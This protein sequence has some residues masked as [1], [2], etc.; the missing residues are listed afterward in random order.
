MRSRWYH[1][2]ILHTAHHEERKVSWLELFYDLIF[3]AGIIQLGDAL[4]T[5]VT[6]Q[7]AV[8]G[9][10]AQF[11]G[12]FSALW[13][14]WTGFTFFANRFDV[15]D[16][17]QRFLVFLQMFSLGAMAISAPRVLI[18]DHVPFALANVFALGLVALM[19][20]RAHKQ[21]PE[22][23]NY[24]RYWGLVFGFGSLVFAISMFLKGPAIWITWAVA[25]F[26]ILVTPFSKT[27]RALAEEFPIDMEHLSERYGLL[28]IIVLGESFVKVLTYLAGSESA[29]ESSYLIK[30][31]LALLV[32]CCIWWIYFDDVA[33]AELKEKRGSWIIWFLGHLPL[34]ISITAV[35][36]AVKKTLTFDLSTTPDVVYV[37]FLVG[38]LTL[39]FFSVGLL[40]SVTERG[41]QE[42]NDKYR[43]MLRFGFGFVFLISGQVASGSDFSAGMFLGLLIIACVSQVIL[44]MFMAPLGE[45][46]V[47]E[48]V[49]M[50]S[51]VY[52]ASLRGE[53]ERPKVRAD[54][55]TAVRRGTP[56]ELRRD[57]YFFFIE[58]SWTRLLFTLIF[59]FGM[60]N[61]GF[62]AL[63]MLDPGAIDGGRIMHFGDAFNFSVQTMS[64]IGYGSMSP[65]SE[66]ANL[67]VTIEAAFGILGAALA[68][69]IMLAKASRPSASVLFS[70]VLVVNQYGG[71]PTLMFRAANAR[72]NDVVEA[73][74]S[75]SVLI[76]ELTPEGQHLRRV[77]DLKL[78]RDRSP[79]FTLTWQ[80]MHVIDED[81]PLAGVDW[82]DPEGAVLGFIVTLLGFD[83]TLGQQVHAR[84]IYRP[85]SLRFNHRYED[86]LS[87]LPDG[88]LMLDFERFHHT[89]PSDSL[90]ELDDQGRITGATDGTLR[91]SP[92]DLDDE[93]AEEEE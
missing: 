91:S 73:T 19:Y 62:A 9:P 78:V 47:H 10:L 6:E 33:G 5:Q 14:A 17:L 75:F 56:S 50:T 27:S 88:R 39:V 24:S 69:G 85:T 31:A 51:D 48:E 60:A 86:V 28:T 58:G 83:G 66:W 63:Y 76:D 64:T 49:H 41:N 59:I 20:F 84:H 11:A 67:V 93:I 55:S 15:D 38:A 80:V 74:V 57:L 36:V 61:V 2:P 32:T 45:S 44:D 34:T 12:L 37:W 87:E 89:H 8:A 65:G 30:A 90:L 23:R 53:G 18:G 68:T 52:K 79:M 26:S 46:N 21:V 13:L 25:L 3:V 22:A 81:S 4:S 72:G 40:D 54:P 29:M 92:R 77:H 71:N 82:N 35:G 1:R 7:H 16:F 42:L 70:D 43:V